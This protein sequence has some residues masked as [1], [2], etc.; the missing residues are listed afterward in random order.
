MDEKSKFAELMAS[1]KDLLS[2]IDSDIEDLK[3]KKDDDRYSCLALDGAIDEAIDI[4]ERLAEKLSAF[5]D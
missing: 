1:M 2:Y 4:Y 5:E 3:N